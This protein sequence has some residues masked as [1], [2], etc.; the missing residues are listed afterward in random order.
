MESEVL[1][2]SGAATV[3]NQTDCEVFVDLAASGGSVSRPGLFLVHAVYEVTFE[4]HAE[5]RRR[6]VAV[7]I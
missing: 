2:G 4:R 5:T 7:N 3:G 6:K 1:S